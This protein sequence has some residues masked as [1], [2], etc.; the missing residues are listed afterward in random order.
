MIFFRW[1]RRGLIPFPPPFNYDNWGIACVGMIAL[2]YD[3][4][5]DMVQLHQLAKPGI[6]EDPYLAVSSAAEKIGFR[7]R[8]TK[9]TLRQLMKEVKQPCVLSL[10]KDRYA[11]FF[12]SRGYKR[13]KHLTCADPSIG[14]MLILTQRDLLDQWATG[15]GK[16]GREQGMVLL[17]EPSF[18]LY[19]RTGSE[20][21]GLNWRTMLNYFHGHRWQIP[22]V[23]LASFIASIAQFIIPFLVQSIIDVGIT[24][25]DVNYI[26]VVL[27]A[28]LAVMFSR[29]LADFIRTRSLL[30]ISASV[31]MG[32]LSDFWIKLFRLPIT[33]FDNSRIG[34]LLQR[35]FDSRKIQGFLTGQL[36]NTFFSSLNFIVFSLVLISYNAQLFLIFL[37]GVVLYFCWTQLFFP[38]RR[39][40]NKK[41][42]N[43]LAREN[44]L[45]LQL[46]RG[47]SEIRLQ[48][49]EQT[50][51]WEWEDLQTE[52]F[53]IGVKN[54]NYGL[55]QQ[56]GA[57]FVNSIKDALLT[58]W[59]ARL[60]MQ[61]R[62]SFGTMFAIQYIIGQLSGPIEQFIGFIQAA[63]DAKMDIGRLNEIHMME[64]EVQREAGGIGKEF[65]FDKTIRLI[66]LSFTYPGDKNEKVLHK[67]NLEIPGGKTTA[68][69]GISGSGKTTLVKLLLKNIADYQGEIRIGDM[70]FKDLDPSFWRRHCA[71]VLHESFIFDDT[72]AKNI[73]FDFGCFDEDRMIRA[74]KMANIMTFIE[75]LPNGFNTRLGSGGLGISQ[76]QRQRLLIARAIYKDP[77]YLFFDEATS[78]LDANN[79]RI[80]LE[81][82]E[83]IFTNRTVIVVAHRLSTIRSADKIIVLDQGKIIEQG[84]HHQLT[85]M[86]GKYFQLVRNQLELEKNDAG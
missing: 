33:F 37:A 71:A 50:K 45:T 80:I 18:K 54:T 38:I 74:C 65:P 36:L 28:Q 83:E 27:C 44:N 68:I 72:I 41:L 20:A 1:S 2:Y 57:T 11:V 17:L 5:H 55:L 19:T 60:V 10:G 16:D 23:I 42:F 39:E 14:N 75:S 13:K 63:Q 77:L 49:I 67:I 84:S 82:M 66:N 4:H 61:G 58:F 48:N 31:N 6:G 56:Y 34:D 8:W 69:V 51:R 47:M 76:G 78:A 30:Y 64:E 85:Q 25:R 81:N 43:T 21:A 79:E 9:L 24:R 15:S 70:E 26:I 59:V 35:V 3:K 40:I 29:M 12:P 7:S 53:H 73:A 22:G 32:V 62:V 46:L 52:I 86:K